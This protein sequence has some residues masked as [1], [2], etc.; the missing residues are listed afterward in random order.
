MTNIL[1]PHSQSP[2]ERDARRLNLPRFIHKP[3]VGSIETRFR[4]CLA[5]FSCEADSTTAHA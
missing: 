5:C 4:L 2:L 3:F 1:C